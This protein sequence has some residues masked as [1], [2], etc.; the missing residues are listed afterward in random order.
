MRIL[1]FNVTKLVYYN[2]LYD[3]IEPENG[4]KWIAQKNT[5][6]ERNNFK[7]INTENG[8][9]CFGYASTIWKEERQRYSQLKIERIDGCALMKNEKYVDGVLV[10][11]CTTYKSNDYRIVGWYNNATIFRHHQDDEWGYYISRANAADCVL[12]P[13]E[14]RFEDEWEA[15]RSKAKNRDYGFGQANMWYAAEKNPNK[16]EWVNKLV[17]SISNYKGGNWIKL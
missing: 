9:F 11:W 8:M 5:A 6:G 14:A 4:G 13:L 7:P 15:P 10:I 2:E 16:Q 3:T 1:F 12:L 17:Y